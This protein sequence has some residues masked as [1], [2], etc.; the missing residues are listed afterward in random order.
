MQEPFE[1]GTPESEHDARVQLALAIVPE[2]NDQV[3]D[4]NH[5]QEEGARHVEAIEA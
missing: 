1:Q 5:C 3:G 4:D 2:G